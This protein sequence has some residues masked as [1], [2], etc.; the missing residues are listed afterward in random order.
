MSPVRA[1]EPS[2]DDLEASANKAAAEAAEA[3]RIIDQRRSAA[4]SRQAAAVEAWDRQHLA[5]WDDEALAAEEADARAAF[6]AAV[7][8]DPV[9]S[10]W[11]RYRAVRHRRLDLQG[12]MQSIVN[13]YGINRRLHTI[14]PGEEKFGTALQS[15]VD[16]LAAVVAGDE[17]D[18]RFAE[19]EAAGA[20]AAAEDRA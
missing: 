2:L 20:A 19:R 9:L 18:A 10:A 16:R 14:G 11:V 1:D 3:R 15:T 8:A 17:H 6:V 13:R 5:G 7:E 12:E 4:M